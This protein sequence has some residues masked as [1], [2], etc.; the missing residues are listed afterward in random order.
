MS[1]T[2]CKCFYI[3]ATQLVTVG[4]QIE[5]KKKKDDG[6]EIFY[7][8][9][10]FMYVLIQFWGWNW[11]GAG[12]EEAMKLQCCME[13]LVLG[14]ENGELFLGWKFCR[15]LLTAGDTLGKILKFMVRNDCRST[16]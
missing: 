4:E 6:L 1:P 9:F 8:V 2:L 15:Y 14:D 16:V 3:E 12:V 10:V 7:S 5:K 11:A 13:Y